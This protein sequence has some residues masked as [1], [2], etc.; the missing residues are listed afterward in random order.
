MDPFFRPDLSFKI[1][2][3]TFCRHFTQKEKID[4]VESFS[5]LPVKGPVRL[6]DPDVCLQYIEYYGVR[7]NDPPKLPY[8]VF[9]G[10][11]VSYYINWHIKSASTSHVANPYILLYISGV[12]LNFDVSTAP[13]PQQ[14][15]FF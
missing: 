6:K 5:Y 8:D 1:E 10:R 3:E 9:F 4:K 13:H 2:V 7:A 11:W 12:R 14:F 15:A